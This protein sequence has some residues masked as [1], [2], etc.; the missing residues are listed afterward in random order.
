MNAR[1]PEVSPVPARLALLR[2]AMVRENLAAY[3]VPSA[4]PHLSE[5]LPERWQARRWL[6]GFTGSVGTLVVTADFAGLWVDSRYWVQA[7][8]ELAGTGV[9]LMKM[10]GGQ[11]SA[12]HVDWLA[13]NVA[14]GA[15]VGVD[16]AVLGVTAARGLTAAL[17]A[18]GI[19]LRT[20]VDLLDAIW[21]ERPG[22]P[23]DAVFE[24]VAPQADTTRA[25]K[26][27]DVRRAMHAQGA[28]WHFVSTLDDLAW[29]FNLRG[30]DVNFNPVFVAHAMIGTDRATLFVADGKVPPA[31]AASLAQDG[32]DVRAYD[33]ARASLAALPDGATLLIDPRRVTF[34][35]LEAVPAGVKL[36]EAVNPSTFAK[37]RKT[38]AEIE[39][40]RVTME[41]DGAALAEFF[42]W[43]EQAVNRE[44]ITELTIEEKL[45]AARARRPGYVS[46]SFATIAGFNANGAMPHYHATRESHATIAGD[47]LLLID[48]GG[49][50]VTGTTDITRVVPVG[51]VSDLQRRDFTIVLKS[52][53]ALSRA[54]FP[55]G[56][57]SPMLDAI[58]RAP[59]WAAGLDYGHGTGHGVGYFLNV[60]EGPQVI[61][62][63]A[64]AEPYTA[65]EEGMITSIEPGVYRPGQWGIR[66]ENLVVNRAAGQTEFGDF[67]AFETLTLCPID[68]RCVL[69]EMLHDEE[70]AWLNTYHATVRERV[71]RHVSGDAKAWLDA[72]TQPI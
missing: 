12:P 36:V 47:G 4:D 20:D 17:S 59:M 60:H 46:A 5:Y 16:G 50:Y 72:R 9:Q 14:A 8:A 61:S 34:G 11:Q 25:S 29:L 1:L 67:L 68:T 45:T 58:A 33:A 22:L 38:T 51:T 37:S 35:T 55:R 3:L 15:T 70:R 43:F 63:Y 42:A 65:M 32:V 53:M 44:T 18:R 13:Q 24:H 39:H 7:D 19:A 28:Q 57:R 10:T 49:Q 64:P 69:I 52:M 23:G 54:R 27:A 71:G 26:L 41:H 2:D 40:V 31:L 6:S 30:A 56:I 62:H 66:I 48:S 21:P